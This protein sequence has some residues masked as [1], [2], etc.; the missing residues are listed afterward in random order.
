MTIFELVRIALNELYD[1][2]LAE[3]GE[4]LDA[5]IK[6]RMAYLSDQYKTLEDPDRK[7]IKYKD[8]AT[9]FAYTYMYVAAHGDYL[10]QLLD[11]LTLK[12]GGNVFSGDALRVSC[13]G[14]GPRKRRPPRPWAVA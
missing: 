13:V 5:V 8:P 2:G 6:E 4:N 9:R 1:E 14:G 12:I 7:R 3:H 10:V 11:K